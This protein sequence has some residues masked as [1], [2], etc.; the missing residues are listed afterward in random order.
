MENRIPDIASSGLT[1]KAL[2]N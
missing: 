1:Q 2:K